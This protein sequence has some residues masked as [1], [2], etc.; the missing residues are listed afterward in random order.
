MQRKRL[1]ANGG[2]KTSRSFPA[3]RNFTDLDDTFSSYATK[4][5]KFIAVNAGETKLEAIALPP[6][7]ITDTYVV[8]SQALMLALPAQ[9]GDV[10]VRTDINQSFI[11]QGADPTIL[12]NWVMLLISPAHAIGSALHTAD[13]LAN[14]KTKISA[15]DILI[16]SQAAEISTITAKATP[17]TGDLFLLEDSTSA[18]VNQKKRITYQNLLNNPLIINWENIIFPEQ[19]RA[20]N[21]YPPIIETV[22]YGA[23]MKITAA[24]MPKDAA[25]ETLLI[26][27]VPHAYWNRLAAGFDLDVSLFSIDPP[28]DP[29]H[30]TARIGIKVW[31]EPDNTVVGGFDFAGIDQYQTAD[32]PTQYIQQRVAFFSMTINRITA[33][34]LNHHG[35]IFIK[36][37]RDYGDAADTF[38]FPVYNPFCNV[39]LILSM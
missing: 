1:I 22:E 32:F 39:E 6:L 17:E 24:K 34:P 38:G 11:L 25:A 8:N 9:T 33:A 4:A 23:Y 7:A 36:I 15:P 19:Y 31:V 16:T 35:M 2:G 28:A 27:P 14:F 13:T 3:P 21:A 10:A 12:A 30:Q 37:V 18:P 26:I 20:R 29:A 5:N